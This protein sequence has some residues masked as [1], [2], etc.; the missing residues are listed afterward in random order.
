[1]PRSARIV[2]PGVAH[3]LTQRGNNKQ[4][5]FVDNEDREKYLDLLHCHSKLFRTR[6]VAYCI[7][8]N[9]LHLVAIPHTETSL[10]DTA[11]RTHQQYAD[12]FN[13]KYLRSGH[14]WQSRFFSCPMDLEHTVN[15]IAYAELNPVRAHMVSDAW[16]YPWSSAPAHIGGKGDRLLN[17]RRWFDRY[18]GEEWREAL[19]GLSKNTAAAEAVRRHTQKGQPLGRDAAFLKQVEIWRKGR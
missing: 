14:V 5:V 7:M 12:Y 4:D 16:L 6:I 8:S 11:S 1:M 3:H 15:A 19:G 13:A 17:L 2:I 10:A 9:H 18:S